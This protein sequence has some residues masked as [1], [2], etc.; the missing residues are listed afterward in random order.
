[1]QGV[2]D[3]VENPLLAGRQAHQLTHPQ[4]RP[5]IVAGRPAG[6]CRPSSSGLPG[7]ACGG[8]WEAGAVQL[9]WRSGCCVGRDHAPGIA[10]RKPGE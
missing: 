3:P 2:L 4:L 8:S 1:M 10:L 7:P 6:G 5:G 9:V